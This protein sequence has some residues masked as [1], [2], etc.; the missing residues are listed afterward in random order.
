MSRLAALEPALIEYMDDAPRQMCSAFP[1][2]SESDQRDLLLALTDLHAEVAPVV[3]PVLQR[4]DFAHRELAVTAL[5]WSRDS[6]VA[7]ALRAWA[8]RCL[9]ASRGRRRFVPAR[10]LRFRTA[11][12]PYVAILQALRG[13]AS[14]ETEA[15]LLQTAADRDPLCRATAL[16]SL[17]WWEPFQRSAVLATLGEGRRDSDPDVRLSARA[18]FARLGER[19]ALAWFR[20]ALLSH[21]AQRVHETIQ[22]VANEGIMLLW[23][24]LDR[25]ADSESVDVALHATEALERLREQM[26]ISE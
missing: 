17:G 11:D 22:V 2:A 26:S 25:L 12:V 9:P 16:G 10:Y 6:R 14:A 3:M 7:P 23:P 21:E 15:L 5:R 24:D 13:H 19:Q 8:A 18:A 20:Q 4:S 1:S